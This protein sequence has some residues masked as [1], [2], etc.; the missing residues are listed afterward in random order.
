MCVACFR[1][2]F[3]TLAAR[4]SRHRRARKKSTD[5]LPFSVPLSP[6]QNGGGYTC[7]CTGRDNNPG[8][9]EKSARA[10]LGQIRTPSSIMLDIR[11]KMGHPIPSLSRV[12]QRWD[13]HHR[14]DCWLLAV[15]TACCWLA[16]A[17]GRCCWLLLMAAAAVAQKETPWVM[18]YYC[19]ARIKNGKRHFSASPRV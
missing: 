7:I 8:S 9:S 19:P 5:R 4:C 12:N 13:L 18:E 3:Q 2:H 10:I 14:N 6:I 11:S 15:T 16:A 1:R 17:A